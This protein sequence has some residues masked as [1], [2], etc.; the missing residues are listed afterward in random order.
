MRCAHPT[1]YYVA[2]GPHG[3]RA[4][5]NPPGTVVKIL[6]G[7]TVLVGTAGLLYGGIRSL[8]MVVSINILI[9]VLTST[10]LDFFFSFEI[11]FKKIRT[12]PAPPKTISKEWEEASNE[13]AKELKINPISGPYL[14]R[15]HS[16]V[17]CHPFA[18]KLSVACR[19]FIGGLFWQGLCYTQVDS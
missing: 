13:R 2:F 15:T 4:P 6:T 14:L 7:I 17:T 18:Y 10:I 1:A 11:I 5:V 9:I 19:Y 8:G 12:A 3:P 16:S